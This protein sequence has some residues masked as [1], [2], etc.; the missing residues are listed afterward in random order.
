MNILAIDDERIML[1]ELTYELQKV[2]PKAHI[3]SERNPLTALEWVKALKENEQTLGYA[4]MDIHMKKMTGL[5]LAREIKT[6]FPK[7]VLIFC[8]AYSDYAFD[9]ISMYAK[10]YLLKPVSSEDII[11]TLDEMVYDWRK[12]ED[13]T[14]NEIKIQTFGHFEIFVNGQP[15]NFE[16][17]KAKELLAYLVDRHGASLTT[18]QI[19]SVLW[20]DRPYDRTMKNYVST[21]L[22]SL[23]NALKAAGI[24]DILIK[25]RNHLSIDTDKINCDAY[26]YERGDTAAVKAFKGEYMTNYSWAEFTTGKYVQMHELHKNNIDKT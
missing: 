1:S 17:E 9:A 21:I 20:E 19:A 2:F 12:E 25:S 8:T 26:D 18:E 22:V 16:R 23:R 7:V 6:I 14:P 3:Q 13:A 15:L 11:T 4:F 5:E 10:G 24:E